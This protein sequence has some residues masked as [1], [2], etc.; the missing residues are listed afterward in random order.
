GTGTPT[1]DPYE[2]NPFAPPEVEAPSATIGASAVTS[3]AAWSACLRNPLGAPAT[4]PAATVIVTR[5]P[6]GPD[7]GVRSCNVTRT[8]VGPG[9]TSTSWGCAGSPPTVGVTTHAV[10]GAAAPPVGP[11]SYCFPPARGA[12]QQAIP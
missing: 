8:A 3:T 6:I 4:R 2:A 10:A 11:S 7:P 1:A 5:G 12:A 9:S